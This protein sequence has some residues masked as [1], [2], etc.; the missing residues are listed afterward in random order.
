MATYASA[1]PSIPPAMEG[2]GSISCSVSTPRAED[3]SEMTEQF[4]I[5]DFRL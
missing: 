3:E 1:D 4:E 2:F 5:L